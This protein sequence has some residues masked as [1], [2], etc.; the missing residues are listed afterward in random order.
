VGLIALMTACGGEATSPQSE[1]EE[2]A[3]ERLPPSE[4]RVASSDSGFLLQVGL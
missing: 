1:P 4:S 2:V 3:C